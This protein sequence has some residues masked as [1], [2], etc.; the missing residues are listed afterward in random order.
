M[1][2]LTTG[3]DNT[4]SPA[5][6]PTLSDALRVW[7]KIGL[8]SF[9]GPAGQIA[10]MHKVLVDEKKWIDEPRY[11]SALNFCMLLPGPE[12]MQLATYV[13]W[14]LHGVAGGLAAGLLFV[15]PGALVVLAL[16]MAYAAFGK[17]PLAEAL[18]V[19]VKAAV[20]AIVVEALLR[21]AKRALKGNVDWAIAGLA[22]AGIFVFAVPFPVIVLAAAFV[23]Y[24]RSRGVA[25]AAVTAKIAPVPLLQTVQTVVLWLVIWALPLLALAALVGGDHVLSKL[26]LFFSKLA[27]VTFGGAYAV[28]AYMAQDVVETHRWLQPGEMLDALGLAETTPG[29]LIL[30]TEFVGYLSGHRFGGGN[31][32]MMGV[33][34]ALVALWATFAPC[35]LW[36]FAG[37]PYIE[38]LNAEPRLKSALAAVTAA[39]VGV[40][41][42]LT[43]WFALNV[44]FRKVD[45]ATA[46]PLKLTVPQWASIDLRA[47]ALTVLAFVL[48]FALHRGIITTLAIC[49]GLAVAW[50]AVAGG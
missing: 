23:G 18:F 30:V 7:L 25:N 48:L 49:G 41:L 33:L 40:I 12:A 43:V 19:G 36:I 20:L 24:L 35:F 21:V 5:A 8:L 27:V 9:G 22:F 17:L 45:A 14:R 4:V 32:V 15:I 50:F 26:S 44:L 11:L 16:S 2:E 47:L 10:L 6:A 1:Q 31:P 46:G 3:G 42:N 34:G 38:R 39:V 13:G 29:P 37:A 28:L